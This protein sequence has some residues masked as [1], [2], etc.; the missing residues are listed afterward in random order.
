MT[1]TMTSPTLNANKPVFQ[2]DTL[3]GIAAGGV[4]PRIP[5]TPVDFTFTFDL[6]TKKADMAK[7]LKDGKVNE[8][9]IVFAPASVF[10]DWANSMMK[11]QWCTVLNKRV[12]C[13]F[14]QEG[15]LSITIPE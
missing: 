11:E 10:S 7:V 3:C 15:I 9:S 4:Y 12:Q 14:N 1:F 6:T 13:A 8:L 2:A 5:N